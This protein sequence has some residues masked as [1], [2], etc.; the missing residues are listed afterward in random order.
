[1]VLR[2]FAESI[3]KWNATGVCLDMKSSR[4]YAVLKYAPV[5]PRVVEVLLGARIVDLNGE[6]HIAVVLACQWSGHLSYDEHV[7][8]RARLVAAM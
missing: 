2:S 7:A 5:A 4:A 8:G 6:A 3:P 1:M